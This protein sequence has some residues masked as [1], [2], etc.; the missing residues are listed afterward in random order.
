MQINNNALNIQLHIARCYNE[1]IATSKINFS[2]VIAVTTTIRAAHSPSTRI[3]KTA[4]AAR[5]P[6][7]HSTVPSMYHLYIE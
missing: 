5:P 1:H 6:V 4:R 3:A 7:K 2:T